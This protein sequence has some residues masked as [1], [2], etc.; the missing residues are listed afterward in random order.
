MPKSEVGAFFLHI[1]WPFCRDQSR[2]R[3]AGTDAALQLI[4][5]FFLYQH[6]INYDTN[7]NAEEEKEEEEEEEESLQRKRRFSIY[8]FIFLC[9]HLTFPMLLDEGH[10]SK[11]SSKLRRK[12]KVCHDAK[13]VSRTF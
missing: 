2:G 11:P 1:N 12:A 10:S 9:A 4:W 8:D 6:L 13:G 5:L 3:H 7:C